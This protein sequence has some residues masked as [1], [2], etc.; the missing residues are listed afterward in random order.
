MLKKI[1]LIALGYF[2]VFS[3]AYSNEN[4]K[5]A[6]ATTFSGVQSSYGENQ[7]IA[8]DL[9]ISDINQRGG[10]NGKKIE[11][12][13]FDDGCNAENSTNV[14]KQVVAKGIKFVVGHH[15][16]TAT[17][18]AAQIYGENNIL[19][20]T[21]S[22]TNPKITENAFSQSHKTIFRT[23]GNDNQQ[24]SV[25][26]KYIVSVFKPKKIVLLHDDLS[27]GTSIINA[28]R[29][30]LEKWGQDIV[31]IRQLD[32]STDLA[33]L[34]AEINKSD[35][36]FVF[37]GGNSMAELVLEAKA[38]NLKSILMGTETTPTDE[39]KKQVQTKME[40]IVLT[41]PKDLSGTLANGGLMKRLSE[42]GADI[43]D[44]YLLPSYSA[45]FLI[46]EAIA[47]TKSEDPLLIAD[48]LRTHKIY[49][50]IGELTYNN[51]GDLKQF[52]FSV[53]QLDAQGDKKEIVNW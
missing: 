49:T 52:S 41:F 51:R 46:A 44:P 23:I 11:A 26:G 29:S 42:G 39:F 8:T 40:N 50:N 16:S 20:V 7:K 33:A 12:F 2:A 25:A 21:A 48:Y 27:Y 30:L 13:Y 1:I 47:Q 31:L 18:P 10:I 15:C 19:M 6:I 34:V 9:A 14:A 24:A 17:I 38:Q 36:D 5:I 32:K 35:A 37:F 43:S 22:A 3:T 28:L 4:I 45:V 53:Y